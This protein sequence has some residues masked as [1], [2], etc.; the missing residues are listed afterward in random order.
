MILYGHDTSPYVRRVRVLLAEKGLPFD[1][2]D[3]SWTNPSAAVLRL[4]PMLRVPALVDGEQTLLDSKLIATYLCERYPQ[5]PPPPP[6]GHLPLQ[7]TQWHPEHRWD[8]EN[9]LLTTDAALDSAIN[10]FLLEL[11]GIPAAQAPYLGRQQ[12]RIRGCLT[13]LDSKLAAGPTFHPG[14]FAPIDIALMCALQW[15]QFRNRYPVHE[16]AALSRFVIAHATRPSLAMTHPSLAQGA[17]LPKT[18]TQ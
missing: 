4:N 10:V 1:R 17:A 12:Q 18:P 3:A 16:H 5:A 11:D 8:D 15:M 6:A 2:D 9:T 7:P 14:V 13:W